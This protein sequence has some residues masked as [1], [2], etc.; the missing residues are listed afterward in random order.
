MQI[1]ISSG[2]GG[3]AEC[4]LA[5][6]KLAEWLVRFQGATLE[7]SV[8]GSH[9]DA[10]KSAVLSGGDDLGKFIGT[11]KWVCQSPYRPSHRRKNWFVEVSPVEQAEMLAFDESR[12][13]YQTFRSRGAGGQNVNKLETGVRATYPPTGDSTVC[14]DERSQ[15]AN[16][17][18]ALER[19]REMVA[20]RNSDACAA[21]AK[22]N[23]DRHSELERG[24]A[25]A[26]FSGM[27]FV[28]VRGDK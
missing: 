17:K 23:W 18:R 10:M 19:L 14:E 8:N 12:V 27:R 4:E 3:P 15:H 22:G 25:V 24:N 20:R 6:A 5:V 26:V 11:V 2:I 28:P 9:E 1:Q 7:S 16:K 21:A 13:V